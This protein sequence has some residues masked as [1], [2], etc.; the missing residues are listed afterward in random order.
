M[1][2]LVSKRGWASWCQVTRQGVVVKKG[3]SVNAEVV[4]QVLGDVGERFGKSLVGRMC[5]FSNEMMNVLESCWCQCDSC[6]LN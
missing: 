2:D 5:D 1:V 6:I 4:D 3:R